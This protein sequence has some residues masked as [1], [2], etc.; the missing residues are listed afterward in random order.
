MHLCKYKLENLIEVSR[1]ASLSGEYYTTSGKY[2]RLTCG[3]FDY[4]NNCF[5]QNLSKGNIYYSGKVKPEFIMKRGDIITPL[6][7]QAIGLLGSTARIPEDNVYIQ[8]Q[9]IAKII[10]KEDLIDSNFAF[11]LI[12]SSLVKNQLSAAAQQTK[13]RHTS[14]DKIKNCV[15]W[16]PPLEEQK[17]MGKL[18]S[19]ID[20]KIALNCAINRNLPTP[21]RSSKVAEVRHAA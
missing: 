8:S 4:S 9:D 14:P 7:E 3:N 20:K 21:D 16:I 2:I 11:Y 12:S 5:K 15:V 19:E 13:I 10:C 1:G 18:L 17:K 6:T